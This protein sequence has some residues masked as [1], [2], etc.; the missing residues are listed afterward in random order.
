MSF[1]N[2]CHS[3]CN[4]YP[5][6]KY[7]LNIPTVCLEHKTKEGSNVPTSYMSMTPISNSLKRK[8][9]AQNKGL[10]LFGNGP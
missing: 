1:Q 7:T 5:L 2:S 10:K 4:L 9:N 3:L 8:I 6:L